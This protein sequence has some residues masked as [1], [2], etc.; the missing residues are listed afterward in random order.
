MEKFGQTLV[1]AWKIV[2]ICSPHSPGSKRR[3]LCL[4][5]K[6]EITYRGNN[7]LNVKTELMSIC[8][9]QNEVTIFKYD[10]KDWW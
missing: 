3:Y 9:H 1:I 5:E 6:L 7:L 4:N 10:T 2:R 8:R